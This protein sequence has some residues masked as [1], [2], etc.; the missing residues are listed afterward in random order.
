M[1][2]GLTDKLVDMREI[3]E[4]IDATLPKPGRPVT[5][6]KDFKLT[7]Y[8]QTSVIDMGGG[9]CSRLQCSID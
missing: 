1:A 7:H 8:R 2:S 6:K 4:M 5:Y 9:L 3:A